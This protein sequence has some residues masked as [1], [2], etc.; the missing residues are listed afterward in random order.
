MK[1]RT[2]LAVVLL[3]LLAPGCKN[4]DDS[5]ERRAER[6]RQRQRQLTQA[7]ATVRR[8]SSLRSSLK[9]E[10]RD[11]DDLTRRLQAI[12]TW[13]SRRTPLLDRLAEISRTFPPAED[14][15]V[16]GLN[17]PDVDIMRLRM[18]ARSDKAILQ[19]GADLNAAGFTVSA[20]RVSTTEASVARGY[21]YETDLSLL[22]GPTTR[23]IGRPPAAA[24]PASAP[25]VRPATRPQA[26][27]APVNERIAELRT[28]ADRLWDEVRDLERRVARRP[29]VVKQLAQLAERTFGPDEQSV[30]RGIRQYLIGVAR[31]S[32]PRGTREFSMSFSPGNR[33]RGVYQELGCTVRFRADLSEIVNLLYLI[34]RAPTL[35]RV[36][37]LLIR[38]I[39][40]SPD[41]NVFL[42]YK[43]L[44]L[45][46][47]TDVP[48]PERPP[49]LPRVDL[50]S[51]DRK[52]Y[53][54]I[55]TRDVFVPRKIRPPRLRPPATKPATRPA[56]PVPPR[57]A[58]PTDLRVVSL[59]QSNGGPE[60]I[61]RNTRTGVISRY[62]PGDRLAGGT[63]VMVDYRA[64]PHPKNPRINSTS[65]LLLEIDQEY[66]AV[67][68]GANLSEKRLLKRDELPATLR[69]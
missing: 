63:I 26:G 53:D 44:V 54:V 31:S 30:T 47:H 50:G 43:T 4:D 65:R 62:K 68:L 66:W 33:R 29:G 42:R 13:A 36:D 7:Q 21:R 38:P 51:P 18:M 12:R 35:H 25:A 15:C 28:R 56:P 27:D 10:C 58:G 41:F 48:S 40:H 45:A 39:A 46:G 60:I 22:G 14:A 3:A 9:M 55:T 61:I 2:L 49:A 37:S 6:E 8:L 24:V 64:M 11:V 67:E 34:S 19:A 23:R 57:P 1:V 69:K 32:G 20:G 16:T 59:T 17:S 5:A 52:R